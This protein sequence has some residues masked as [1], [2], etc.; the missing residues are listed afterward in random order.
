M[1]F[2]YLIL[3]AIITF[4]LFFAGSR[5]IIFADA[6]S[7]K[8]KIS[9]VWIGMIALSIVTSLPELIPNLSAV[10]IVKQPDLALG[11]IIGSNIFNLTI[12]FFVE[13]IFVGRSIF[14]AIHKKYIKPINLA[15]VI[16]FVIM[17]QI[18]IVPHINPGKIF[19]ITV[20]SDLFIGF[21]SG[22]SI[23]VIL[24]YLFGFRYYLKD[25]NLGEE[26][27]LPIEEKYLHFS[28]KRVIF[29]FIFYSFFIVIIGIAMSLIA[30]KMSTID[31]RIGEKVFKLGHTFVG[32]LFLAFATSLPEL[33]VSIQAIRKV[34]SV[35]LAIGN[36]LGSNLFNLIII[37]ISDF[38]YFK[39]PIYHHTSPSH[40]ISIFVFFLLAIAIVI[41]IRR[42]TKH[43]WKISPESI[44]IILTYLTYLF[45]LFRFR[46]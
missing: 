45:I 16:T 35:N 36:V 38:F 2:I 43:K 8:T 37:S 15:V 42:R 41:G 17:I 3:F 4:L 31:I 13:I 19:G 22:T 32:S 7:E 25:L 34:N 28:N 33:V 46:I 12:L 10:L 6:L 44:F 5:L 1:F 26:G 14:N 23:L 18:L 20:Y 21:V 9:D 24:L 30:D 29:S 27:E 40:L 39:A 11:N